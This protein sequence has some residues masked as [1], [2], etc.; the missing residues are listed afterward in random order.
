M[1]QNLTI[2]I[3]IEPALSYRDIWGI[4]LDSR[5]YKHRTDAGPPAYSR[6]S[7]DDLNGCIGIR[8]VFVMYL[9]YSPY[10]RHFELN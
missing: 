1:F 4:K 7:N 3:N 10:A 8:L 9:S 2:E 5:K 6:K